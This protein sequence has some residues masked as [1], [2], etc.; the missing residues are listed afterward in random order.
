MAINGILQK[1]RDHSQ[2]TTDP[3]NNHEQVG[4]INTEWAIHAASSAHIAFSVSD[5]GTFL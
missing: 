5:P 3:S 4:Y 1:L 2:F